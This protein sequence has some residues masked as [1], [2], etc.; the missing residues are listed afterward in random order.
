MVGWTGRRLRGLAPLST[1]MGVCITGLI[2]AVLPLHG[3]NVR[4]AISTMILDDGITGN[5]WAG[6][7]E[8]GVVGKEYAD[9]FV[10]S[11][12]RSRSLQVPFGT[13]SRPFVYSGPRDV[14]FYHDPVSADL[15]VPRPSVA[16]Q[17]RLPSGV[18]DV[19][20][21]F[22]TEDFADQRFRI[23]PVD[24]SS[25]VAAAGTL[26]LTNL[27]PQTIA[28]NLGEDRGQIQSGSSVVVQA[29][30]DSFQT[31][32][33]LA[34]YDEDAGRWRVAYNRIVRPQEGQRY[35]C[36]ILPQPRTGGAG[37]MVRFVA[38][39][40]SV[41]SSLVDRGGVSMPI[42]EPPDPDGM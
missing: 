30:T 12:E 29:P 35:D 18:S 24:I 10:V 23:F 11:G 15:S 1:A 32:I 22:I 33:R 19:L 6:D 31:R 36:L 16:A 40:P 20:L 27:S 13:P 17:V 41:R 8:R 34:R 26:R 3:E 39:T 4:V 37:I 5:L 42:V 14:L 2:L 38:D 21:I 9:L 28:W 7:D 25:D